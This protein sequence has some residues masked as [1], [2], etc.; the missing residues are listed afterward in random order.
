M[1]YRAKLPARRLIGIYWKEEK[2][3]NPDSTKPPCLAFFAA[4]ALA[5]SLGACGDKPPAPAASAKIDSAANAAA[6]QTQAA[7]QQK[8]D[9]A[10]KAGADKEAADKALAAKVKAAILATPGLKNMA[11]DVRSSGG[12]VTLYGTADNDAQRRQAEKAAAGVPG[13]SS[14]KNELLLVRGS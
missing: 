2:R 9:A 5:L 13:V 6:P 3:M 14:V 12:A 11:M 8:A 4:V 10:A 1:L 7:P